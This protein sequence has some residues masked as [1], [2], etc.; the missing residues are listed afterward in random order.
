M[1]GYNRSRRMGPS[2]KGCSGER[3]LLGLTSRSVLRRWNRIHLL[4][5]HPAQGLKILSCEWRELTSQP[6]YPSVALK[7]GPMSKIRDILS[8]R[9]VVDRSLDHDR[10]ISILPDY[11]FADHKFYDRR[12]RRMITCQHTY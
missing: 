10:T 4:V 2:Q 3:Y 1:A 6:N 9:D 5:D 7:V 8:P 12:L 11:R